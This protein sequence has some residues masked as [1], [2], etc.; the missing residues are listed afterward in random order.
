MAGHAAVLLCPGGGVGDLV[1][2]SGCGENLREERVGIEGDALDQLV[3]LLRSHWWRCLLLLIG[4]AGLLLV[5]GLVLLWV[6]WWIL[7][8][9]LGLLLVGWRRWWCLALNGGLGKRDYAESQRN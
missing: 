7:S 1:P 4:C 9:G 3:K 6:G 5:L 2:E 8:V